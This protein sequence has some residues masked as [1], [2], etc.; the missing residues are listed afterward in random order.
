[1]TKNL[2]PFIK[3]LQNL[4]NYVKLPQKVQ[5]N[6]WAQPNQT[7]PRRKKFDQNNQV[8]FFVWK[9]PRNELKWAQ[10]DFRQIF[11]LSKKIGF[12]PVTSAV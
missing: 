1:M 6:K 2:A 5:I 9:T 4:P 3:V 12:E 10:P 7:F 11:C 8:G